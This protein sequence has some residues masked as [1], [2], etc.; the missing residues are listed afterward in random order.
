MLSLRVGSEFVRQPLLDW[1]DCWV[2]FGGG[3]GRVVKLCEECPGGGGGIWGKLVET[4]LVGE[5]D[6]R[7]T[8][9]ERACGR[10]KLEPPEDG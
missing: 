2:E 8:D 1:V 3:E 5:G 6:G 4:R 7:G 10:G 9:G